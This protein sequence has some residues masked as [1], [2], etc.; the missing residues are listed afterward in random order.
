LRPGGSSAGSPF[1]LSVGGMAIDQA[2]A[3]KTCWAPV[4]VLFPNSGGRR[5]ADR[6]QL[7]RSHRSNRNIRGVRVRSTAVIG[8]SPPSKGGDRRL[9][10]PVSWDGKTGNPRPGNVCPAGACGE[11]RCPIGRSLNVLPGGHVHCPATAQAVVLR[12]KVVGLR[13]VSRFKSG[14]EQYLVQIQS[15]D[16]VV[17]SPRFGAAP[18]TLGQCG[19]VESELRPWLPLP[20]EAHPS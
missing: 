9:D 13:Q 1:T 19:T 11:T 18:P 8:A 7:T 14:C 17:P 2:T 16:P 5:P 12:A 3:P 20:K 15:G 6:G 4:R 10:T